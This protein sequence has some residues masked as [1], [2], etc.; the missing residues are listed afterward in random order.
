MPHF[1]LLALAVGGG[2][3]TTADAGEIARGEDRT[4]SVAYRSALPGAATMTAATKG[5]T[6]G[7]P[8]TTR[9]GRDELLGAIQR[10][11]Y[12]RTKIEEEFIDQLRQT[13]PRGG[14]GIVLGQLQLPNRLEVP[15]TAW[16]VRFEFR[17]PQQGIGRALGRGTMTVKGKTIKQFTGSIFI[18]REAK[19]LQVNR[20][21]RRG[22]TIGP[23]DLEVLDT[24]LSQLPMDALT[25][26]VVTA[27]SRA[28]TEL[29]PGAW[30]TGKS[31]V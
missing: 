7:T 17:L 27:G 29:R 9:S 22:E 26:R 18:D 6:P 15:M 3:L 8:G 1:L 19:G 14:E 28:K 4:I 12:I 23:Y 5:R 11:A 24:T 13:L 25:E 21:V 30:L 16:D 31:V 2:L 10:E 20:I